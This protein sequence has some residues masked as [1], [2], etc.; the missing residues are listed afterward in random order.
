MRPS[1]PIGRIDL[2]KW[3]E[4]KYNSCVPKALAIE[5]VTEEAAT[6]FVIIPNLA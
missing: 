2:W 5:P 3:R 6:V 4:N 1:S